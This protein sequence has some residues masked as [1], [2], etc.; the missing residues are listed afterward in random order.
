LPARK[1]TVEIAG[2]ETVS[3]AT[4]KATKALQGMEGSGK[5]VA[6]SLKDNWASVAGAVAGA[7]AAYQAAVGTIKAVAAAVKESVDLYG[8]Q[9]EAEQGLEAALR[10]SG[11]AAGDLLPGL[12]AAASEI[13]SMTKYGDEAV[14]SLM[15]MARSQG[16]AAD[17]L[18]DA[19]KAAIGLTEAYGGGL[20]ENIRK[21]ARAMQGDYAALQ[22]LIPA[23]RS[24]N[25]EAEKQRIA[26][27]ALA[28]SF[29]VAKAKAD[30][31]AAAIVQFDNAMG[32]Y[33][34]TIGRAVAEGIKPFLQGLTDIITKAT[35]GRTAILDLRDAMKDFKNEGSDSLSGL[36]YAELQSKL[37]SATT[38]LQIMQASNHAGLKDTEAYISALKE[39]MEAKKVAH[40]AEMKY[41]AMNSAYSEEERQRLKEEAERLAEIAAEK[42]AK[43]QKEEANAKALVDWLNKVNGAYAQTDEGRR[44]AIQ[45]QI[46][47]F[48]DAQA[49]AVKTAHMFEPIL[50]MLYEQLEALEESTKTDWTKSQVS[51]KAKHEIERDKIQEA[52]AAYRE[53]EALILH[54]QDLERQ[55]KQAEHERSMEED[56]LYR[57]QHQ[58]SDMIEGIKTQFENL[59]FITLDN[60]IMGLSGAISTAVSWFMNLIT[61]TEEFQEVMG[62]V[63]ELLQAA[64]SGLIGPLIEALR[65]LID[66]VLVLVGNVADILLPVIKMF[67]QLIQNTLPLW[68]AV[69][70]IVQVAVVIFQQLFTIIAP[71]I[72]IVA[73]VLTPF[74]QMFGSILSVIVPILEIIAP[75]MEGLAFALKLIMTP[76]IMVVSVFEWMG[77]ILYNIGKFFASVAKRP[78]EPWKWKA[79]GKDTKLSR[80]TGR[81]LAALW[82]TQSNYGIDSSLNPGDITEA[83]IGNYSGIEGGMSPASVHGGSTTVQDIT[84]EV[85]VHIG[86]TG[87]NV[88]DDQTAPRLGDILQTIIGQYIR[89]GG[90]VEWLGA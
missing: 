82:D 23:M 5:N 79:G 17:S 1:V 37:E 86:E 29:E 21:V 84:L 2:K 11:D 58:V 31:G 14:L 71:L 55:R 49:E 77:N 34:E 53:L 35:E 22:E 72:E 38:A 68:L 62:A 4:G 15:Q 3:D 75:L 63:N 52:V 44:A 40:T 80:I 42:E 27:D 66:I 74:L 90:T 25:S 30:N 57:V 28:N 6:S 88:I 48:K 39:E 7:M 20:Q 19:A 67:G 36:G 81:N 9:I 41:Q 65:P 13:Q 26:Q 83:D 61:S 54:Y 18:D 76:V 46:A 85:H 70:N 64:V 45:A 59:S 12:K 8:K 89:S 16:V 10:A 69:A 47:W 43:R 24:A 87:V 33:K 32:D 78:L 73:M 60:M 50:E 56:P 51:G